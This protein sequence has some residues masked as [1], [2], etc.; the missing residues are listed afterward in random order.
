MKSEIYLHFLNAGPFSIQD[1]ERLTSDIKF[2]ERQFS[3]IKGFRK[4]QPKGYPS[5]AEYF[6]EDMFE[7]NLTPIYS[8]YTQEELKAIKNS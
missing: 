6:I 5:S 3:S 2:L 7:N 4:I 8:E 1:L